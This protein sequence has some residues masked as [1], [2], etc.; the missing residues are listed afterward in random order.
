MKRTDTVDAT[1]LHD[2]GMLEWND[3]DGVRYVGT[4]RIFN[5]NRRGEHARGNEHC[6]K[7]LD[8]VNT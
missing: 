7:M 4:C 8:P 3:S 5:M 6:A 1:S 2:F